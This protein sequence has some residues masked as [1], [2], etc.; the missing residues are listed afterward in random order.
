MA[1]IW[2]W[3]TGSGRVAPARVPTDTV[4]PLY[5]FDDTM[6]FASLAFDYNM[7]FEDVL[8]AEKLAGALWK[9]LE[10]PGW[11]KLGARLR[12]N[13]KGKLEYHVPAQYTKQ[14][15]PIKFSSVKHDFSVADHPVHNL[16]RK[17]NG[18]LQTFS[19]ETPFRDLLD[20]KDT[21]RVL[22]DWLYTDTPQLGL[23]VVTFTDATFVT[24]SWG[25]T[26]LD[27]MGRRALLDAWVAVLDG[28]DDDVLEFFGYDSDPLDTL[29]APVPPSSKDERVES[30]NEPVIEEFVM[31]KHLLTGL[32]KLHFIFNFIWEAVFHPKESPRM[33][34]MPGAYL[35]RLRQEAHADLDTAPAHLLTYDTQT[36]KPFISDGDILISW[37]IRLLTAAN[38][39]LHSTTRP[40]LILNVLGLRALINTPAAGYPAIIPK[41]KVYIHNVAGAAFTLFP[42]ADDILTQPLGHVAARIRKDL[43]AQST[44]AQVEAGQRIA[45]ENPNPLYGSGRMG[46]SAFSNWAKAKLYNVDFSAAIIEEHA[47]M[48]PKSSRGKPVFI[49]PDGTISNGFSIRGSGNCIGTDHNGDVWISVMLRKGF[50]GN[51]EEEIERLRMAVQG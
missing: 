47:V 32:S 37:T 2:Q 46:L 11:R 7:Y 25:H 36:L 5:R 38:P 9:L 27:A 24:L 44:R 19:T 17:S 45:R 39:A 33:I 49:Q 31:K 23:H 16:V 51:L 6:P 13:A 30:D 26:L 21:P 50:I 1:T 28:R 43:S 40:L 41:D 8:D 12:K 15:P 48:D 22:A 14:R 4:I 3:L 10:R 18:T 42:R 35:A 20:L 29:G 34:C